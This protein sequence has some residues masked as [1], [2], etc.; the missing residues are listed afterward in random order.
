[1]EEGFDLSLDR[2]GVVVSTGGSAG[3]RGGRDH[4]RG[5]DGMHGV[6]A[7]VKAIRVKGSKGINIGLGEM[8]ADI[9]LALGPWC[10]ELSAT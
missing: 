9:S 4:T 7:K 2:A 6:E 1:M 8:C 10:Q 5:A 3:G